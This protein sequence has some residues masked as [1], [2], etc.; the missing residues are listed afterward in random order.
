MIYVYH[1]CPRAT[2]IICIGYKKEL[3][4]YKAYYFRNNDFN[5]GRNLEKYLY[6]GG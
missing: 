1:T 5:G 2:S 4:R 3:K 6:L